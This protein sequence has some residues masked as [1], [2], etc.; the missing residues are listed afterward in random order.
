[1]DRW[2]DDIS[3][4][5]SIVITKTRQHLLTN[6]GLSYQTDRQIYTSTQLLWGAFQQYS[7]IIDVSHRAVQHVRRCW[8]L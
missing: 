7:V 6:H 4:L 8:L 1:M 2:V 5:T 3:V